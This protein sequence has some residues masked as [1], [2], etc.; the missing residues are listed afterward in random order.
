MNNIGQRP[1][2]WAVRHAPEAVTQLLARYQPPLHETEPW[3]TGW[4][5][6]REVMDAARAS[7]SSNDLKTT[8]NLITT[9][10]EAG[11]DANAVM[12]D[13]WTAL[14]AAVRYGSRE[15]VDLLLQKGAKADADI[16]RMSIKHGQ[17]SVAQ[18]LLQHT[19]IILDEGGGEKPPLI[20]AA[21]KKRNQHAWLLLE[22]GYS[23]N[24]QDSIGWTALHHAL[25]QD[26]E[27]LAWLLMSKSASP[28]IQNEH[29]RTAIH[30]AVERRNLAMLHLLCMCIP[31]QHSEASGQDGETRQ[32][33]RPRLDL[34]DEQG[35]TPIHRAVL[36]N[37]LGVLQILLRCGGRECL[38]VRDHS[39]AAP[40]HHA[41]TL[42]WKMGSGHIAAE[43]L[44]A[45]ASLNVLDDR[46]TTPLMWAAERGDLEF[47]VFLLQRGAYKHAR[48][49][50]NHTA[51]DLATTGGHA[52]VASCIKWWTHL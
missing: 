5:P 19:G 2:S 52:N 24:V 21:R 32:P 35:M 4:S 42:D 46:K 39:G 15:T 12:A 11:F 36:T 22:A 27:P 47:V 41:V 50:E 25:Q 20:Y 6:I 1:F 7:I 34:V 18:L 23:P 13:G 31:W 44:T 14:S 51:E 45:G 40:L 38:D 37:N 10:L 28:N 29:K 9:L 26:N 48:D 17:P 30:F 3:T 33:T 16:L 43:L 8:R 49:A